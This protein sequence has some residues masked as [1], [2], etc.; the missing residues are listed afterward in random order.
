MQT[1]QAMTSYTQPNL[2]KYNKKLS[3]PIIVTNVDS[4]QQDFTKCAPQFE[5]TSLVTM[6]TYWV[7]DLPNIKGIFGH[8]WSS[9]FVFATG[10][11][12]T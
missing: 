11:S 12:Y 3:Q 1:S 10:A 9:I 7:P 8:L 4:L 5:L 6:A 2:I